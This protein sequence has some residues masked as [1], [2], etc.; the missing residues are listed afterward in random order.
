MKKNY[1]LKVLLITLI[2]LGTNAYGQ[3][4]TWDGSS[5]DNW[6]VAANWTGDFPEEDYT[7]N[8]I[9]PFIPEGTYP[10]IQSD[11]DLAGDLTIE[12]GATLTLSSN[13]SFNQASGDL[14]LAGQI[15]IDSG[16]ELLIKSSVTVLVSSGTIVYKRYLDHDWHLIA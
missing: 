2:G 13:G 15:T 12:S 9:I 10:T 5:N 11:V 7:G 4:A 8:I 6:F 14:T 1:F 3:T 16:S